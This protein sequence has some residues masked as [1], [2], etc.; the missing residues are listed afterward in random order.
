MRIFL[1]IVLL[2]SFQVWSQD[3]TFVYFEFGS[4]K[5]GSNYQETFGN[6]SSDYDLSL[7]DSV[8]FVGYADSVGKLKANLRLSRK[9]AKNVYRLCKKALSE[10]LPVSVLARGEDEN[11]DDALNRRVAIILYYSPP[12]A[13]VLEIVEDADP[14]CFFI[15][16]EALEYCH[17]RTIKK[18]RK[19]IVQLE[20]LYVPLFKDRTHY[21]A[22]EDSKGKVKAQ[23]VRWKIK[24]TGL[25]W[26]K[27][28]RYVAT[29]PKSSFDKFHFFTLKNGPC[30]GCSEE[31]ITKDTLIFTKILFYADRFLVN[32]AQLKVRYFGKKKL[33]LRV[34]REYV[35]ISEQYYYSLN[36]RRSHS[37][38][39]FGWETKRGK[40]RQNYYFAKI[41][42]VENRVPWVK[43]MRLTTVC[44]NDSIYTAAEGDNNG[45]IDCGTVGFAGGS[46]R[47]DMELGSFYQTD[48]L[49]AYFAL[50][51]SYTSPK[52]YTAILGGIN[53]HGSFYGS[54][55]YQYN[56]FSFPLRA[57][58][59]ANRWEQLGPGRN[60]SSIGRFYIG[61][62]IKT[63]FNKT[64]QSFMEGNL[65][66]GFVI[67][68]FQSRVGSLEIL[69]IMRALL[70]MALSILGS[71]QT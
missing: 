59:V 62:E 3:T 5:V 33:K 17:T 29:I 1:L 24:S 22:R 57:M 38:N 64:D 63:S 48:S 67:T 21:Y 8:Q 51:G 70:R 4:A 26:W 31:V 14:R 34:P 54:A 18:R 69:S 40:K 39:S 55:R 42:I 12:E 50:G 35:D 16:F 60:V 13:P 43:R 20:A 52:S 41:P 71:Q 6:L 47:L 28:K 53:T 11:Q 25:L 23:R 9:R 37:N 46:F 61:T 49:T 27:K 44:M 66:L 56:Y 10:D 58:N 36:A 15:D 2:A 30:D 45:F 32:N 68:N 65:H 19:E 7:V